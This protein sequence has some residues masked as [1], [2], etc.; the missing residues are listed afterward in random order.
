MALGTIGPPRLFDNI[1]QRIVF[2]NVLDDNVRVVPR[3]SAPNGINTRIGLDTAPAAAA[4]ERA[5][6]LVDHM[7]EFHAGGFR[8]GEHLTVDC[9]PQS[10]AIGHQQCCE[11]VTRRFGCSPGQAF[12]DRVAVVHD[13]GTRSELCFQK[14]GYIHLMYICERGAKQQSAC[15]VDDPFD[16]HRDAHDR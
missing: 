11:V 6:R 4:A 7:S 2:R 14:R 9:Q 12:R 16:R 8:S 3:H 10:D 15:A 1:N 5:A 13:L